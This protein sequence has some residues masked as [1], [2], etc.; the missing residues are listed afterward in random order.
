MV[1][2]WY[3]G[4]RPNNGPMFRDHHTRSATRS[5]SHSP[6]PVSERMEKAVCSLFRSSMTIST[7]SPIT[8]SDRRCSSP[9]VFKLSIILRLS[10]YPPAH[11]CSRPE[12][13]R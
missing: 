13:G 1:R 11:R 3:P 8:R 12:A 2:G 6:V 4:G 7:S 10:R 5:Y 9:P